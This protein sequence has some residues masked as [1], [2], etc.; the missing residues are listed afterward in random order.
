MAVGARR[1]SGALAEDAGQMGRVEESN[2]R[3]DAGDP[4]Q[5]VHLEVVSKE[6]AHVVDHA[7]DRAAESR[8][9]PSGVRH[10]DGSDGPMS[11]P[12]STG[13]RTTCTFNASQAGVAAR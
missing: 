10:D 13:D 8:P 11:S 9:G 5:A 7:A 3:R 12:A 1:S 4:G 2:V 6:R